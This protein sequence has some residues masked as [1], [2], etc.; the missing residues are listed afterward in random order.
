[1]H[2]CKR[3]F[4][5]RRRVVSMLRYRQKEADDVNMSWVR[6]SFLNLSATQAAVERPLNHNYATCEALAHCILHSIYKSVNLKYFLFLIWLDF[7]LLNFPSSPA[8]QPRAHVKFKNTINFTNIFFRLLWNWKVLKITA[9]NFLISD[10]ITS[11]ALWV[12]I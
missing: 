7:V 12:A 5:S 10:S 2:V 4:L 6:P 1:M 8:R 9:R 11:S 3:A